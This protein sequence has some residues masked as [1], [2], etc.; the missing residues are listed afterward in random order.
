MALI[1]IKDLGLKYATEKS[2]TK[3]RRGIFECPTCHKQYETNYY[4]GISGK[5]KQCRECTNKIQF[6]THGQS[7]TRLY[8]IWGYMKNRCQNP[9]YHES[10]YYMEKGI[11]VCKEWDDDFMKFK[12]WADTNGYEK[13]LSIDRIDSD[14][15]YEP[16]N[17][18]WATDREQT[19]NRSL[20]EGRKYRGAYFHKRDKCWYSSIRVDDKL[21]H[22]GKFKT[23]IEAAKAYDQFVIDN[24]LP[25]QKNFE[26]SSNITEENIL[27]SSGK[28]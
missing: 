18:R 26:H 20:K 7:K 22:L 23:E 2:K 21:H 8:G 4:R 25:H 16:S 28:I 27:L 12:E 10:K 14:G 17:C 15:N 9:N 3:Q 13:H 6:K 1:L 11:T 24:D 19:H 5:V